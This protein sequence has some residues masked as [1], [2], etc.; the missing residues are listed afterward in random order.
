MRRL[1]CLVPGIAAAIVVAVA[2]RLLHRALP[3]PAE[4]AIGEVLFALLLGLLAANAWALPA[5]LDAGLRFSFQTV[6]RTAI[7]LLGASFSLAQLV[8]I[9]LHALVMIVGLM[10]LALWVGTRLARAAGIPPR[11]GT[12]LGVG[13][14]VCGNTA[15]VA[16]AP[17]IGATDEE[18]A[19]AVAANT[20]V[21]TLA[22]ITYPIVGHALG[23]DPASFG[24][25]AGT[26]VNDTS[27]VLATGF[28]FSE[29]SGEIA[30]TVKLTR[31]ALMGAVIVAVSTGWL[32]RATAGEPAP[33]TRRSS[34]WAGVPR[35]VLLFLVMA[36]LNSAG[37]FE[38]LSAR[39]G[40]DLV[41]TLRGVSRF[42]VLVALAAV[43]LS[44]RVAKLRHAGARPLWVGLATAAALS[45]ASLVL[46][47]LFGPAGG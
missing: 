8:S 31:N 39:S 29:R 20:L 17:A 15:I 36:L 13:T 12:L 37:L 16:T 24:T 11:L 45:L 25:W 44:T 28:A 6:L 43:G 7:V 33:G 14:A 40:L 30:T 21:G 9:G 27:Q 2:A 18:V 38:F 22:V 3:A 41:T 26:A 19:F 34:G 10:V 1:S 4:A 46:I 5:A 47:A 32:G 23:L 42:L 35:F